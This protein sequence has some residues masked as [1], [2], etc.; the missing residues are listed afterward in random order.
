[1]TLLLRK[2]QQKRWYAATT[3]PDNPLPADPLADLNTKDN[4]LSLWEVFD[5]SSNLTD[6]VTA[7]AA[8][9]QH[10]SNV[11]IVLFDSRLVPQLG[12]QLDMTRAVTPYAPA[13]SYHRDIVRLTAQAIL[14]LGDA[15]RREGRFVEFSEKR[16]ADLLAQAIRSGPL[17]TDELNP[18]VVSRL[19]RKGLL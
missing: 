2:V 12:L 10:L 1:M 13:A 18:K 5:D 9:M 16:V 15:L 4:A 7:L 3:I 14:E 8:T 19:S 6:V 17:S 11:D